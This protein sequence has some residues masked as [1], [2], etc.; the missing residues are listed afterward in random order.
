MSRLESFGECGSRSYVYRSIKR[1][2]EY[3]VMGSSCHDRFCVPC[4]RERAQVLAANISQR[5]HGKPARF[6]TFTLN[7]DN[8]DLA[9]SLEKL[10]KSFTRLLKTRLWQDRVTGGVAFLEVKYNAVTNR[11]HPHVHAIVQGRY[12]PHADLKQ[13][14]LLVTGDSFIVDIRLVCSHSSILHYVTKY[15]SKAHR[16]ADFPDFI[17]L[18]EAILCLQG[19]HL[20]RTFGDWRGTPLLER[21]DDAEWEPVATLDTLLSQAAHGDADARCIIAALPGPI[22]RDFLDDN[23]IPDARPPP[24]V[25]DVL[26]QTRFAFTCPPIRGKRPLTEN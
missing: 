24:P 19:R 22:A 4:A 6:V 17:H 5:L 7:T 11:W 2:D 12:I 13:A 20:A 8:L 3:R 15:C 16:P 25:N 23:P 26:T 10:Q 21:N 18:C 14:W 9:Q 1:P